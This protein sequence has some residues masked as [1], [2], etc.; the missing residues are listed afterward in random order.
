M[1]PILWVL[2]SVFPPSKPFGNLKTQK[3]VPTKFLHQVEH[4]ESQIEQWREDRAVLLSKLHLAQLFP[5]EL[6]RP[7]KNWGCTRHTVTAG[8]SNTA[9]P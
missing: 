8:P 6:L 3:R 1:L 4:A 9:S 2:T 7:E 5:S